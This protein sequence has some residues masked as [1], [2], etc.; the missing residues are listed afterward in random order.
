[1]FTIAVTATTRLEVSLLPFAIV[2]MK[3]ASASFATPIG[4]QTNLM[5]MGPGGYRFGDY[6][7]LGVPL[8][9]MTGM[10]TVLLMPLVWPFR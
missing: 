10:L 9:F 4:Y 7:R 5:V 1:M 2:I 8:T 3:A 6:L